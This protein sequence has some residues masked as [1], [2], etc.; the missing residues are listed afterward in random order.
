MTN[1]KVP[2]VIMIYREGLSVPQIKMQLP[3]MEIPALENMVKKIG[4][5]T[6]SKNYKP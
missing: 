5:K 1:K 4:D 3:K 6:N 2:D